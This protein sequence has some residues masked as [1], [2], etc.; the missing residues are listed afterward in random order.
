MTSSLPQ[1]LGPHRSLCNT[2]EWVW[3]QRPISNSRPR[4]CSSDACCI[5]TVDG[6]RPQLTLQIG[7]YLKNFLSSL[8]FF[9]GGV[10]SKVRV[11]LVSSSSLSSV[12]SAL[13][14]WETWLNSSLSENTSPRAAAADVSGHSS[15]WA[16]SGGP[17]KKVYCLV[18]DCKNPEISL[19]W[20]LYWQLQAEP[21]DPLKLKGKTW[22]SL[23]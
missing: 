11:L 15:F 20:K 10:E 7:L 1:S 8:P 2:S 14:F 21:G 9:F 3:F 16:W 5:W 4:H 19:S 23:K 13:V 17:H 12:H 18:L 6:S 22:N